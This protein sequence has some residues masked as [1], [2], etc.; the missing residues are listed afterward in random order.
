ML[1]GFIISLS[2]VALV[3]GG[4]CCGEWVNFAQMRRVETKKGQKR[5]KSS[6][7]V[8]ALF[9]VNAGAVDVHQTTDLS[10]QM[11]SIHKLPWRVGERFFDNV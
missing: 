10:L 1:D 11:N 4:L 2:W 8:A 5:F 9:R 7:I 6:Q 3:L